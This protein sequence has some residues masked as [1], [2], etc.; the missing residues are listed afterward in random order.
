MSALRNP[1]FW[2]IAFVV[3]FAISLLANQPMIRAALPI[4]V[5]LAIGYIVFRLITIT[6]QPVAAV[7]SSIAD[8]TPPQTPP[9]RGELVSDR[10]PPTIDVDAFRDYLSARVIGQELVVDQISRV[11]F[12]RQAQER[13]GKPVMTVLLSGPTGTGKTELAKAIADY[14]FGSIGGMF[15]VD[16]AN[17]I[18]EAGLQT[19]IGSPKGYAGSGSWG[20]LTA[21]LRATP[22][23]VLLFD[24]LEK[25]VP[26]PTA[27]MAK[28]LLSLLDEGVCTEQ[29]DGTRVSAADAVIIMTSNAAHQQL[30]RVHEQFRDRPDELIRATKDALRDSLS[31]EFLARIDLVTTLAPLTRDARG[32]IVAMHIGRIAS[33]YGVEIA[34][35]DA[36]FIQEALDR[37]TNLEGYGTREIIRWAEDA[38]AE[39]FIAQKTSGTTRLEVSWH[40]GRAVVVPSEFQGN[41]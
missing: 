18:G 36:S 15:R 35:I 7:P 20:T 38:V 5:L 31:P 30:G 16:C 12:R 25:A 13:R 3:L 2:Q 29:S 24:E 8:R 37:W 32:R 33:S 19:L 6:G 34:A 26:S 14:L 17:V 22:K 4:V 9:I 27:P 11:I 23:T 1:L 21:H 39:A 28:L 10:R 40:N 41:G